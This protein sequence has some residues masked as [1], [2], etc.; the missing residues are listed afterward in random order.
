M[1]SHL[2]RA[3]IRVHRRQVASLRRALTLGVATLVAFAVGA[4]SLGTSPDASAATGGTLSNGATY[5]A[6]GIP[7]KGA[8]VGA[9][10]GSN[11]DPAAFEKEMGRRL[12]V[13]RTYWQAT[14]V[15]NAVS[16]AKADIAAGRLPWMSF[17]FPHSWSQMAAGKGDAWARDLATKLAAL[18]GPV[19]LAFHHEPEDEGDPKPWVAAQK[20][21]SPIVRKAAPNVAFTIIL[22]GYHQIY[23]DPKFSLDA[24][25]PG[26]GLVDVIGFDVYYFYGTVK[27]GVMSTKRTDLVTAYFKHFQAFAQRKNVK[28]GLAETGYTDKASVDDP[29]WLGRT[30]DGL[31]ANGGVAFSYFNTSLNSS[32]SWPLTTAAKKSAFSAV[33]KRSPTLPKIG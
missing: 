20:R 26:D 16:V 9:A 13:R 25:W 2:T 15:S 30:Y 29:T 8:F 10:V 22:M 23:G 7:A 19:W 1:P 6:R 4:L 5:S 3:Q 11:A 27:N 33:L 21:L 14:Q 18:N 17:K 12:G 24:M 31:V 32:A 28:W